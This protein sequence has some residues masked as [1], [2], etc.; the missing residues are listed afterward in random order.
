LY[1]DIANLGGTTGCEKYLLSKNNGFL[2][3][4]F[5]NEWEIVREP[6]VDPAF[7]AGAS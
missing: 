3:Q 7:E 1:F 5:G 2:D 6:A 4:V